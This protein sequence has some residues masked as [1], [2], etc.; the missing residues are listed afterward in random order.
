MTGTV[1]RRRLIGAGLLLLLMLVTV[2]L[3]A[4]A[5]DRGYLRGP[6]LAY[7]GERS[8]RHIEV[9][10]AL[11]AHILTMHPAI[12]AW[13]V[14]IGNPAWMPPGV[15]ADAKHLEIALHLPWIGRKL[16]IERLVL[17][18]ATLLL[19]RD[20]K[21]RA[22]WQWHDPARPSRGDMP[23]VRVLSIVDAHVLLDD[24]RRHLKFDGRV[25]AGEADGAP[26]ARLHLRGSGD[27]NQR[28]ATFDVDGDPLATAERDRP[29]RFSYR[30]ESSGSTLV[31]RGSLSRPF[32]FSVLDTSFEAKGADLKD[33][34]YLVGVSL[35]N[36]GSYELTGS[37]SR[38]G[39]ETFFTG[40]SATTGDSD[41][42]GTVAVDSSAERSKARVDLRSRFLRLADLG[43]RAAGREPPHAGAPLLLSDAAFSSKGMRRGDAV[44]SFHAQH[45]E[46]GRL[47]LTSV[48]GHMTIDRGVMAIAP[49]TAA[50]LQGK[51]TARARVDATSEPPLADFD[52]ETSG[53]EIGEWP[54]KDGKPM[55]LQGLLQARAKGK[56][57]GSSIHQIAASSNGTLTVVLPHGAI[58][59]SLAEL[60][61][62]DLKGLGLWAAK[63]REETGVRCGAASFDGHDG[64]LTAK[65]LLIDTDPVLISGSGTIRLDTEAVDLVLHGR[66]KAVRLFRVR[67]PLR[68]DGTLSHPS[69]SIETRKSAGQAAAAV[70]LGAILT[71]LAAALAFVDPGLAKNADCAALL[72]GADPN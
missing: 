42:Q 31:G 32:D 26:G 69:V 67:A 5:V 16:A 61:G 11:R 7:L 59:S 28:A 36:T 8:G 35:V 3:L 56:G 72:S 55:G 2:A 27:L 40:L 49:L 41:M 25:S 54:R 66:P 53:V 39:A 19:A 52:L 63:S 58:R 44:V 43:L 6:L 13:D 64:T 65:T 29:Y 48:A 4:A 34:Y 51:L 18:G 37:M 24:E 20:A 38:R 62:L 47:D 68:V 17:E 23:L 14:K 71:P 57:R 1:L 15:T 33:L 21:G 70:A 22:N 60:A 9:G 45:V 46:V 30:E 50:L 10:G 12:D